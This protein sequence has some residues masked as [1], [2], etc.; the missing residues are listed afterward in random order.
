MEYTIYDLTLY[1]FLY[2]LFG[3][4][5]EAGYY[6]LKDR[7]FFNRG[8]LSLP[9][10][11]PWGFTMVLMLLALPALG[12]RYVLQLLFVV[13]LVAVVEAVTRLITRL[14][15]PRVRWGAEDAQAPLADLRGLLALVGMGGACYLTYLLIHP[16]LLIPVSLLPQ[17]VERIIVWAC[18][19]VL[20]LDFALSVYAVRT[21]GGAQ[22][23]RRQDSGL[24]TL[25]ARVSNLIWRRLQKAYPGIERA[26]GTAEAPVFAKGLCW[27]KLVWVFFIACL[28]GD[29]TEMVYCRMVGGAWVSRSSLL[30][31]PFSLVWGIGGVLLTVTLHRLAEK[32][33]RYV[34]LGGFFIGGAYEYMCSVFTELVFGT[35]FW[36]YSHMPLNIGGRT[37]VLFC[38]F[39]GVAALVWMKL[40]YPNLSRLI[41]KTPVLAGKVVTW[42]VLGLMVCNAALTSLAMLRY[43]ARPIQPQPANQ[44]EEFL[45]RQYDDAFMEHR[46]A[47]MDRVEK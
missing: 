29:L 20:A 13:S 27:D 5:L 2:A 35:V 19:G 6:A 11:A 3:W 16:L 42:V 10:S 46:W 36:D 39:W 37:N 43:Q 24:A 32:A 17:L 21:G 4:V 40:I 9:L 31:G 14:L 45:D 30:Y 12:G 47:N 8:L 34:F 26:D 25:G 33:D 15:S 38:F 44:L 1:W 22:M 28:V 23:A 41:E 18:L 7:G